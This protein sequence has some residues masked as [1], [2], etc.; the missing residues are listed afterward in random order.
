MPWRRP[1]PGC[2]RP[3]THSSTPCSS[4]PRCLPPVLPI[5][6]LNIKQRRYICNRRQRWASEQRACP[7]R[8]TQ[9]PLICEASHSCSIVPELLAIS[10]TWRAIAQGKGALLQA[11]ERLEVAKATNLALQEAQSHKQ[12]SLVFRLIRGGLSIL[13]AA[14]AAQQACPH[15]YCW[16]Q[17]AMHVVFMS[18]PT[19]ES[20]VLWSGFHQ[21]M[22]DTKS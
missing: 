13:A 20:D 2:R 10:P 1:R 7:L 8:L 12:S 6:A 19:M 11:E 15:A 5:R 3:P 22:A 21:W 16:L 18:Q 9:L 4:S 17:C 14:L